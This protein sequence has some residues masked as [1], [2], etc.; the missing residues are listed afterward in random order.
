MTGGTFSPAQIGFHSQDGPQGCSTRAVFNV[1]GANQNT[2]VG[3][4][5][6]GTT[7]PEPAT[8]TLVG[9]GIAGILAARRRRKSAKA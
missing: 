6:G 7:V 4:T 3:N 1:Q 5:C 8:M 2:I 9:T